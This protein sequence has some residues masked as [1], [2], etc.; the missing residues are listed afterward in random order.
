MGG[1]STDVSRYDGQF[2]RRY[3]MEFED[4]D[5][6]D[7]VRIV[8]PMLSIETVAA[9]GGSVCDF[10]GIKPIVGPRSAGAEPGPACYGRGGPLCLTDVNLYLGRI[11]LDALPFPLDRGAVEDRLD[12]LIGSIEAATARRYTREELASGYVAIVNA[13]MAAA[14]K[15]ISVQRGY[16]PSDHVLVSFGGAGGQHACAVARELGIS[17]ILI[18][19][20]AGVLSAYGIGMA[21]V[22]AFAARAVGR[23]L[24]DRTLRL[25]EAAFGEMEDDLRPKVCNQ[26]IAAQHTT[27]RR[28]LDLR[29]VGQDT[30]ITVDQS[31]EDNWR[32]E[33][34]RRHRQ[35]YGFT[36]AD[37]AV[38]VCA[39]RVEMIGQTPKP[40]TSEQV[41]HARTAT[42]ES[43][44]SVFFI[45]TWHRTPVY[46]RE[47]LCPRD[48]FEGPAIVL[49]P[50]STIVV[51]PGWSAQLTARGEVL[52]T[53]QSTT[54]H[55]ADDVHAALPATETADPVTLEL[56]NNHFAAIAEQM[57]ATLQRTALSTNVKER[58]DYSCAIYDPRGE[59]VAHAPHNAGVLKPLC[60]VLPRCLLNP[61]VHEDATRCAAVAGGNVETSQR[62]VDTVFG[63]LKIAAAS[64][65]TM[66]NLA[67]GSEQLG[68]YETICG[69]SGAGPGFDGADAVHTHMTNTRLTD[70]EVLEA[71][72]PVR[73][74]RFQIRRGS[75]GDGRHHGGCGVIRKLEFLETLEVSILSRRRS[76]A[77]YGLEGG[78]NGQNGRNRLRRAGSSDEQILPP[79]AHVMVRPG[80]R[81]IIETPGGGGYGEAS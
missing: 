44:T 6:G 16:D 34:E 28:L 8:A 80:D 30:P 43:D 73:M 77:P 61:P 26:G 45:D 41:V 62:I 51:E 42:P 17:R 64:Q 24:E 33:F 36:F 57:G 21:D 59:L 2:E 48:H 10:D 32:V 15:R 76:T 40:A 9:G 22:T 27:A 14:I 37:R 60:I 35:L 58:R 1:T 12:D 74:V 5:T 54:S 71:R 3:E 46:R 65:G 66:N 55:P 29:Y 63:A 11:P 79:V 70:P 23:V 7:R 18:H 25:V 20:F 31:P 75:G 53:E 50:N 72:Y 68:Y 52:L 49:E 67:F 13:R 38:E 56:F 81:L 39:A 69:G 47:Q 19:P 78:Q 4:R